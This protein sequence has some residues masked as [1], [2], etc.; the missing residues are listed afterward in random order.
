MKKD[1]FTITDQDIEWIKEYIENPSPTGNEKAGQKMWLEHLTPF[2][3]DVIH[4]PYGCTA[5]IVN[6]GQDFKVV[7]EAHSDEIAWYVNY[8]DESGFIH[9]TE[10]GGTDAGIAPAKKVIIHTKK[11][12]V[13]A[14]FGWPAIHTRAAS[15]D[16]PK[17]DKIFIDCGC[18][19]K[20]EVEESGIEVGDYITYDAGFYVLNKKYFVGRALDNRIGG[21]IIAK[22]A[23]ML[24]NDNVNL[25][26]S[27][28][29][30][31]SV[32]EEIGTK[33]AEMMAYR[34]SPDCVLV[35]DVTHDTNTPM[36]DKNKEGDIACGRGPIIVKAPSIH[37]TLRQ[38]IFDTAQQNKIP[39]QLAVHAKETGTDADAFAYQKGGIPTALLSLPLRYMHTTVETMHKEDIENTIRL[40]YHFLLQLKPDVFE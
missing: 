28:Y 30:V 29:I 19:S 17:M 10:T 6:P 18:D 1:K 4:T 16:A 2:I 9:V 27:L 3:D 14:V 11:G 12:P 22:V 35:V 38:L 20:E 13:S 8:I 31:N 7:I 24:K 23:E 34:I 33:G 40:L 25:P 37:L 26:Y 39:Y 21:F 15:D 5:G 32:Q 36:M